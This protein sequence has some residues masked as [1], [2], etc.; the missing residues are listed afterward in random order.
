MDWMRTSQSTLASPFLFF[1]TSF[2]LCRCLQTGLS[3]GVYDERGL[4]RTA[5][6]SGILVSW[7]NTMMMS[8]WSTSFHD[9]S[10]WNAW[11]CTTFLADAGLA[12]CSTTSSNKHKMAPYFGSWALTS[13]SMPP[14]EISSNLQPRITGSPRFTRVTWSAWS[15]AHLARHGASREDRWFR[16]R[17]GQV[18]A[19]SE[20][21]HIRGDWTAWDFA[22]FANCM[23]GRDCYF[24]SSSPFWLYGV[25]RWLRIAGAPG[26]ASERG[27]HHLEIMRHSTPRKNP[28]F[29]QTQDLSGRFGIGVQQTDRPPGLTFG[30]VGARSGCTSFGRT[31]NLHSE[32][33]KAS[34]WV[35]QDGETKGVPAS[36]EPCSCDSYCKG[37]HIAVR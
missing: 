2:A 30:H 4:W 8:S 7:R 18:R 25:E 24:L 13:W 29:L 27:S 3:Y 34:G 23:W 19:S 22:N 28:G 33:W 14:E 16:E 12:I 1:A 11:Y 26:G 5:S 17:R 31:A 20:P 37:S 10:I 6:G 21:P 35:I 9:P 32:Y 36:D 15:R